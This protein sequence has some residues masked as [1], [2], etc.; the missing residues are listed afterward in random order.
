MNNLELSRENKKLKYQQS[1]LITQ[2][3]QN[4][5][6]LERIQQLEIRFISTNSL[7]DLI[8]QLLEVYRFE[9]K[10]DHVTLSLIDPDDEIKLI[11]QEAGFALENIPNLILNK[12]EEDSNP[13]FG[14]SMR[15]KLG[16]YYSKNHHSLFPENKEQTGSVAL[17]PLIRNHRLIG[18]LNLF[19]T[20]KARYLAN[21]AT[22]FLQRLAAI[23][24]ICLENTVNNER[25]KRV[26][27][28]DALTGI[29]NRRFFDKRIEE[30]VS[31]FKRTL[32]PL[33]CLIFDIDYFKKINDTYGHQA[34]D[35]A[36]I[37][38]ANII[39]S[40][41]RGTD[42]LA[43]YGGEEFAVLLINT[44]S[45]EALD[46]AERVRKRVASYKF[47]F[48]NHDE[49]QITIS[50]GMATL[51]TQGK[52]NHIKLCQHDLVKNADQAL[53]QAKENGRNQTQV[54]EQKPTH[55]SP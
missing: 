16:P 15:P 28:T 4:A 32:S 2:V 13:F 22:D 52:V 27:L 38:T 20:N 49:L 51:D 47:G 31:R 10:L 53:Y 3:R 11:L 12:S 34:G 37:D 48:D 8:H 26:G 29:N 36:L 40:Q 5:I 41:L 1:I 44:T 21:S 18:S 42:V 23:V 33:T 54:Y 14:L 39:K 7:S 25:L 35:C 43:R 50:I 30:E 19:S 9:A 45:D 17:L 6:K 55:E 24:S 46:I